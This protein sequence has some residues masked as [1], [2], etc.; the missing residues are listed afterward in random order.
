MGYLHE[1]HVSLVRRCRDL[2]DFVVL[3]IYVNPLQF[4][5]SEDLEAYPRDIDRDLALAENAGVDL[6]FL[7]EDAELYPCEPAVVV[8]PRRLADRLCGVSRPG[9]FE[10]VLTVLAKLFGIIQPHVSVFGQKDFQQSVLIRKLVADL[11]MPIAIDVAPTVREDDGLAMSSR[12]AYLSETQRAH[13]LRISR[14]LAAAVKAFRDGEKDPSRLGDRVRAVMETGGGIRVEYVAV[15]S[16]EE[17]ES[18]EVADERTVVAVA[19]QI[20]AT[21]LIDNVIPARPDPGLEKLLHD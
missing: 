20:G 1:G 4:G 11:N 18:I 17:L 16:G 2:A 5:P 21:R 19:A 9:H 12:N 3:S 15:L 8:T 13:A 7:P 10:G 14:A 6:V